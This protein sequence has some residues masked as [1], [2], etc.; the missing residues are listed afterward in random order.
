MG[1]GKCHEGLDMLV[2]RMRDTPILSALS[3]LAVVMQLFTSK[4]WHHITLTL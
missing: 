3:T 4:N 2:N 1:S